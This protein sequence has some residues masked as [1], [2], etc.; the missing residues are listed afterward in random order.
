MTQTSVAFRILLALGWSM[1]R[2]FNSFRGLETRT[3]PDGWSKSCTDGVGQSD[4]VY[5][6]DGSPSNFLGFPS[7]LGV[8]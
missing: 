7:L 4:A 1:D 8:R 6:N 5:I 3:T 2:P